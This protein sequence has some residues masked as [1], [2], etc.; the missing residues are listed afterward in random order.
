MSVVVESRDEGVPGPSKKAKVE[1]MGPV[2]N[3]EVLQENSKCIP[4]SF[5]GVLICLQNIVFGV[6]RIEPDALQWRLD[7]DMVQL[8]VQ[9]LMEPEKMNVDD[10]YK[11]SNHEFWYG[12]RGERKLEQIKLA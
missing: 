4:G 2:E 6:A 10:P 3:K 9:G 8:Q 11:I 7:K 1:A 12:L 5:H